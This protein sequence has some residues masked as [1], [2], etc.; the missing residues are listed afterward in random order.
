MIGQCVV[1]ALLLLFSIVDGGY[2]DCFRHCSPDCYCVCLFI[3]VVV[4]VL[5]L[6]LRENTMMLIVWCLL[7]RLLFSVCKV[8]QDSLSLSSR[9]VAS[10]SS[11]CFTFSFS[12]PRSL[13]VLPLSTLSASLLPLLLFLIAI[14]VVFVCCCCLVPGVSVP[15]L[16]FFPSQLLVIHLLTFIHSIV[17]YYGIMIL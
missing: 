11:I 6:S 9:F 7:V 5:T 8:L 10:V 2:V 14:V 13:S 17:W 16:L 1:F 3:V 12:S 4:V 15:T